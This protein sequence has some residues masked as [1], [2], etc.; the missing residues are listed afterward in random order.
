M[1]LS[2]SLN[3]RVTVL[4]AVLL[5]IFLLLG[6]WQLQRAE[7][8]RGI[9]TRFSA[10]QQQ[11]PIS[12][13]ALTA[14]DDRA[15]V[16]VKLKGEFDSQH[17]FLLDNRSFGG[18]LGYEVLTPMHTSSG[19]WVLVNRGWIKAKPQRRDLPTVP[20][21]TGTIDT[22]GTVY[23]PL[24]EPFL[25]AEQIFNEVEW[26]LVVQAVEIEKFAGL[27]NRELFPQTVR[28]EEGA[29]GALRIDW[30][31]INVQPEKHVGYAVQWFSMA[32]ALVLWFL[33]ANTNIWQVFRTKAVRPKDD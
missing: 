24:S 10:R 28:L 16:P 20:R 26:P 33:V 12:L 7:E 4:T 32:A 22:R 3:G 8:K 17:H 21:V 13:T 1:R 31:P 19:E 2:L 30:Q 27:L 9:D 25:L 5:P 18:Q 6:N 29:P 15:F 23:V 14:L 11:A